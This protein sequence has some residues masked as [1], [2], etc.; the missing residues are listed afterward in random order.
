M[1]RATQLLG[2]LLCVMALAGCGAMG[3]RGESPALR[4][5][6]SG[7]SAES[8]GGYGG[9]AAPSADYG[10]AAGY[11]EAGSAG[12]DGAGARTDRIAPAA[13]PPS[14]APMAPVTVAGGVTT[15][16][17]ITVVRP[18][19]M[20]P[21]IVEQQIPAGGLLTAASVG[22][23]DRR[24]NYLEYLG[25][26]AGERGL[27]GID[28]SRRIRMR[29][30]DGVG[31][32]V[33]DARIVLQGAGVQAQGRTHADGIWDFY[34][35]F[36]APQSGGTATATIDIGQT[37][38]QTNVEIPRHGDGPETVVRLS[39]L[40]AAAP[41]ALD[42]GF[43]IDV[44]GSMEDELRYVNREVADITMRIRRQMPQTDIRVGAT[45]YRDRGDAE[46]VQQIPFSG[47]VQGFA[48]AMQNVHAS[49]G[50]DYPEDMNTGLE[51][52]LRR[53]AWRQGN[54]VRVLVV[55][56]DAPPQQYADSQ[57]TYRHAMAD[58]S[59]R[60]IRIL[61]VAASGAERSV[62]YLFRSMAAITSTPYVYLTNDSGIGNDHQEA[63]TDRVAV[64]QFNRLLVRMVLSDL[65]GE[66][67]HEPGVFGPRTGQ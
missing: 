3:S 54:A 42:L 31:R 18:G 53:M 47:N 52:G 43:L 10:G 26:H 33:N 61:P 12:G 16:T 55:I 6:A 65:A 27:L 66:G 1:T 67:M 56:A 48:A 62:E 36:S 34:P 17:T 14:V 37:R 21:P 28:M 40:V 25:R 35:S 39:G 20:P 38:V 23:V 2:C 41:Q 50:G 46:L 4:T 5:V 7:S 60:G 11:A 63:D 44:T 49:G 9:E 22:D 15:T 58:A 29:V 19:V 45:F 51:F 30:L 13:P 24:S 32:P 64:E 8:S 57:F 59:A